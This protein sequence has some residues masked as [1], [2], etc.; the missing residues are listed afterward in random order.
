MKRLFAPI[1]DMYLNK[2]LDFR[3]RLF[4]VLAT[5]GTLVSL[6][7]AIAS[8]SIGEHPATAGIYLAYALLSAGLLRYA[9]KSGRYQ[10]CYIVTIGAIFLVGFPLFFVNAGGYYGA[11]PYF[12]VFAVVFTVF[13][14][15]GVPALLMALLELV[16]YIGL[17]V[18]AY[19]H[20]PPA[21]RY[22]EPT[23]MLFEAIFGFTVVGLALG[24]TMFFQ[25]RLYNDQQKRLDQQN[26]ELSEINRMKTE[27]FASVSHEMKTPLTVISVHVQR[28]DAYMQL[29]REGDAEKVRESHALAQDEIMRLSRLVDNALRLSS[30]Q[31]L[32]RQNDRL[33]MRDILSTTSEAYRVLLERKNNTLS[34]QLPDDMPTVAGSA[35]ALVQLLSNLLA[36]ANA[37]TRDGQIAV[38]TAC[39][40][41]MLAITV[42][43]TGDG[44]QPELLDHVF[45]RGVSGSGGSGLGL[46][47]CK[48][49][50]ETH[51][52]AISLQS[53]PGK[54]TAATVTLPVC[55][56]VPAH[57]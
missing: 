44:I 30:F 48:Q 36:N 1:A 42:A 50:A 45:E 12:F 24:I 18:Y 4:N 10:L 31:E 57:A 22:L 46:A 29:G 14:L 17:C 35:D 2:Q 52:G 37:H 5:A 19:F 39:R 20:L 54:G 32:G 33:D 55:R 56:E 53:E 47:I 8:L 26:R 51:G 9:A 6:I 28:A 25:I 23:S 40:D 13:M 16:V 41:D 27:F 11:M 43:D 34:L 49:I 15:N 3:V 38:R 21:P 7:S